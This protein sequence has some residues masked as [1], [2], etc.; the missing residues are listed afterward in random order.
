MVAY[1][2]SDTKRSEQR[3]EHAQKLGMIIREQAA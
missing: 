2:T 1:V 3:E